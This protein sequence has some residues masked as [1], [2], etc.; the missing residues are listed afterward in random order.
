MCAMTWKPG[1]WKRVSI[2][3]AMQSSR[4]SSA[5]AARLE[6]AELREAQRSQTSDVMAIPAKLAEKDALIAAQAARIAELEDMI[7]AKDA[8]LHEKADRLKADA[9]ANAARLVGY[10]QSRV[11]HRAVSGYSRG[12]R[13]ACTC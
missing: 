12:K 6:R 9:A 11:P 7:A 8:L 5:A 2:G 1:C 3:L 13:R 4:A 10:V